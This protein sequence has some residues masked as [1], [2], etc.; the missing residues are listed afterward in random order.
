MLIC[1]PHAEHLCCLL[2]RLICLNAIL[3][4]S[5]SNLVMHASCGTIWMMSLC[6]CEIWLTFARNVMIAIIGGRLKCD[7]VCVWDS[8]SPVGAEI[9]PRRAAADFMLLTRST[10]LAT[11]NSLSRTERQK[12]DPHEGFGYSRSFFWLHLQHSSF[13]GKIKTSFC[14]L[15]I[16]ICNNLGMNI[17]GNWLP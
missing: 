10:R 11:R 2:H 4:N 12:S 13:Q 6:K 1:V 15:I 8:P 7:I 17:W 14:Q 16:M 5:N 9:I 3:S